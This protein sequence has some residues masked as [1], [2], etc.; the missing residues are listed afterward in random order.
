[1]RERVLG[2]SGPVRGK[3]GGPRADLIAMFGR[4]FKRTGRLAPAPTSS[5]AEAAAPGPAAGGESG[6]REPGQREPGQREPGEER[7]SAERFQTSVLTCDLGEVT[8]LSRSGLRVTVVGV[9]RFKPGQAMDLTLHSPTDDVRVRGV[10]ARVT[11][12]GPAR[13]IVGVRFEGLDEAGAA[14]VESLGRF[15]STRRPTPDAETAERIRRVTAAM[16]V[17][18]HYATLGVSPRASAEQIHKAFRDLARRLHPDANRAPDAEKQF[19]A[20]NAAHA[21]LSDP[22]KRAEYDAMVGHARAA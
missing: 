5:A 22:Q 18:D 13:F 11:P 8:D 2:R 17:P 10:V 3:S 4:L 16:N 20:V 6:Q 7:R 19:C 15:G 12:A 21:V 1:M 9:C 14:A